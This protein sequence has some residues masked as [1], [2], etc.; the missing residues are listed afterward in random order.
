MKTGAGIREHGATVIVAALSTLF[1][2]TLILGTGV[3]T[4]A[5]DPDL[6]ESSGTFRMVLLMVSAVFIV[7]A[8]Y[9]GAIVTAN[10]FATIIAGRTRTIALLRLVGASSRKV[11]SRVAGEG[12]L[13]G[14]LGAGIGWV[15]AELLILAAVSWGPGL[16]WL[17]AGREYPRFDPLTVGAVGV[18]ALTTWAAAWA[19]SRRVG[20][21]SPIAATGAAVEL[22]PDA[23]RG[24]TAR[25]VWS[26][27]LIILGAVF[28]TLGLLLGMLTPLA[29]LVAFCGGLLSFTGIALGAHIIMPPILRLTGTL[30]GQGPTGRLAAANAV[31]FPER[32]ARSTIGLVIGV[33]LVTMFA[34]ALETYGSM[35]Q[36]AFESDPALAAA[37]AETLAITTAVFTGLVGF[38]AIIAA[39]GMVNTLSLSVLQRTRELGLL[40]ALGFTGGQVRRMVIAES[41]QMTLAALGFGLLLGVFYGWVAAQSLLGS[42]AGFAPPTIPWLVVSGIVVFGFVLAVSAAVAPARRAIRVSPVAALAVD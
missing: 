2:S 30:L 8:L 7:I 35:T 31:R 24:R 12:L 16:G 19:G 33:T 23:A 4:A 15:L 20:S 5:L 18:V 22:R 42:Q 41:C 21:V 3:M 1:A 9:V 36:I 25:T 11:R 40:R 39:V 38:S 6:I 14:A 13:M 28:L 10:T 26:I 34:V 27:I 32:S 29:L 17:P 37:L